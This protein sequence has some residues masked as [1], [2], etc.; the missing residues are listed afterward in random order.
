MSQ[1]PARK[2]PVLAFPENLPE[3]ALIPPKPRTLIYLIRLLYSTG[4]LLTAFYA[5]AIFVLKP[6]LERQHS[7]RHEYLTYLCGGLRGM[8]SA[9][10]SRLDFVPN[11]AVKYGDR[12]YSDAYCQTEI[13]GDGTILKLGQKADEQLQENKAS[14]EENGEHEDQELEQHETDHGSLITRPMG[15][16]RFADEEEVR[17]AE[18]TE[19]LKKKAHVS[20]SLNNL[21]NCL[22]SLTVTAYKRGDSPMSMINHRANISEMQPLLFQVKQFQNYLDI[23]NRDHPRDMFFKRNYMLGGNTGKKTNNMIDDIQN[24]VRELMELTK[25]L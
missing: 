12:I 14:E 4:A 7:L 22:D 23:M 25:K 13:N 10:S 24:Q 6:C 1:I 17:E 2:L 16:V 15:T 5:L 20:S 8:V 9:I 11:I 19:K 18:A 3:S 21:K